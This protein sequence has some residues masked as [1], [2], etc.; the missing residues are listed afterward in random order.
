VED[1]SISV[2][3]VVLVSAV[4]V[5]SVFRMSIS[6]PAAIMPD[7]LFVVIGSTS[8]CFGR[9]TLNGFYQIMGIGL[10]A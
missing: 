6:N 8:A 3:E 9:C 1:A 2:E 7:P 4:I 5:V 10:A